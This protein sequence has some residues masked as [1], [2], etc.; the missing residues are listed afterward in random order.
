MLLFPHAKINLGLYVTGKRPDGYHNISTLFYP[1]GLKDILEFIPD[2]HLG[3]D[4]LTMSGISIPGAPEDNLLLK[5]CRLFRELHPL[6]FMRIHLHKMIP[7][8]AGLG[9]GSSDAAF[10]LRGLNQFSN[11]LLSA[12]SL[13]ELAAE[14]G[15]DCP[16][17]LFNGPAIGQGR[18]EILSP[19]DLDLN[20]YFLVLLHPGIHVSTKAAY[21]KVSLTENAVDF[22]KVLQ[23]GVKNWRHTLH[24]RFEDSVFLQYPEIAQIKEQLYSCGSIYASMSGSGS[25]VYGIFAEPINLPRE[26][27][28]WKVWE[29]RL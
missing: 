17:F 14:I 28:K 26:L 2:E 15:S 29:G 11:Q 23:A 16:Y 19:F 4:D 21:E 12:K 20:N 7:M 25:A 9:G 10:L 8:G 3:Q 1:I 18:G 6:P 5:A 13:S 27:A 22:Q 24:N